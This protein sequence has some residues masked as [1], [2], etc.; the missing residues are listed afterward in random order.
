MRK[1]HKA[2]GVRQTCISCMYFFFHRRH[3]SDIHNLE[4]IFVWRSE[5]MNA[6][7]FDISIIDVVN[8]GAVFVRHDDMQT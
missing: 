7:R 5:I 3:I 8:V 4:A 2:S 1:W 6:W